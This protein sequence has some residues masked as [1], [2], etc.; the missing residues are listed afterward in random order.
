LVAVACSYLLWEMASLVFVGPAGQLRSL[1]TARE[2]GLTIVDRDNIGKPPKEKD[3]LG[4]QGKKTYEMV[5]P[6]DYDPKKRDANNNPQRVYAVPW[7]APNQ[8]DL[9]QFN[10]YSTGASNQYMPFIRKEFSSFWEWFNVKV[11][12]WQTVSVMLLVFTLGGLIEAGRFNSDY[13]TW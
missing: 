13:L 1:T 7:F 3:N 8:K 4:L 11:S 6:A 9:D 5:K 10:G 12:E 2:G